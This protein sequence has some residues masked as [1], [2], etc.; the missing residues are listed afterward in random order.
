[1][2]ENEQ[3]EYLLFGYLKG[4]LD[5]TQKGFIE[6]WMAESEKN[7]KEFE[8]YKRIFTEQQRHFPDKEVILSREK[9][10]NIL[11]QRLFTNKKRDKRII[12]SLSFALVT[13][14][15]VFAGYSPFVSSLKDVDILVGI[16][17]IQTGQGETTICVLPDSTKVWLNYKSKIEYQIANEANGK[18]RRIKIAGEVFFDVAKRK[19]IPF[20]VITENTKIKVYGTK[21]NIKQREEDLVVTLVEGSMAVFTNK[22]E[23]KVSQLVPGDQVI[24]NKEGKLLSKQTINTSHVSFWREGKYIYKD[25]TLKEIV[26]D[27]NEIYGFNIVVKNNTLNKERYRFVIDRKKSLL[28]TLQSLKETTHLNYYINGTDILLTKN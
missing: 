6:K 18:I 19:E 5:K 9:I 16:T 4:N 8:R 26:K 21:F 7:Q 14:V 1:M 24:L 17:T 28:Q 13:L 11:I 12:T 2:T 23:K 3:I 10:K 20:E 27:L 22:E 15:G 25:V